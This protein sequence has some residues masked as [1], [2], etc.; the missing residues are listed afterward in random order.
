MEPAPEVPR[1]QRALQRCL[2]FCQPWSGVVCRAVG[3]DFANQ[4]DLL[5]GEGARLYGGRWTPPGAF[6]AVHA[7]MDPH[8]AL[9]E[10]L[11]TRGHYQ[12]SFT[13][14]MPLVLVAI[15]TVLQ[16]VLDLT[17][18]QVRRTLGVSAKRLIE[19]PW[20]EFQDEGREAI[21]QTIGRL[22]FEAEVEAMIVPSARLV[23]ARNIIIFPERLGEGSMLSIQKVEKLPQPR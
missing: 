15:D 22:V 14:S 7:T 20:R 23:D 6:A 11:G 16:K 17:D 3:I 9:A 1:L 21:T 13:E 19:A 18:G 5:T 8:T 4:R 12:I 2:A 10:A